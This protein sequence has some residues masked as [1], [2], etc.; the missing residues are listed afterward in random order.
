MK[1]CHRNPYLRVSKSPS[2]QPSRSLFHA[3]KTLS[4]LFYSLPPAT[5]EEVNNHWLLVDLKQS[6]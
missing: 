1:L 2:A 6:Q 5:E 3:V 4:L